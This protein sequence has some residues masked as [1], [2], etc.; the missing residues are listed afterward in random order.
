VRDWR[1]YAD[2]AQGLIAI[3][4]PL[5]VDDPFGVD[6]KESVYALDKTTIDLCLSVFSWAPF[7][8]TKAAVKL[9]TLLDLRGNIPTFIYISDGNLKNRKL[10]RPRMGRHSGPRRPRRSARS[11]HVRQKRGNAPANSIC[12]GCKLL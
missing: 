11:G 12:D 2:F 5:Y 8:S 10:C 9:H 7:R 1:I 4:R 3:A 6:L